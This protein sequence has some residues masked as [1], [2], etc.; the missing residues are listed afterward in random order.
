VDAIGDGT[1]ERAAR[2]D[3]GTDVGR[4]RGSR[5]S[6][7]TSKKSVS[8]RGEIRVP[9][10]RRGVAQSRRAPRGSRESGTRRRQRATPDAAA[11]VSF[12][13]G[14]HVLR[15]VRPRARLGEGRRE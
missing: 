12:V 9:L 4:S 14:G 15:V 8:K 11:A 6:A 7:S 13:F 3:L 1:G 2:P 5:G 10:A